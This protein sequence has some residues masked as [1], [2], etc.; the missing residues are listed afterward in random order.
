MRGVARVLSAMPDLL[1]AYNPRNCHNVTERGEIV[2]AH[3]HVL[4]PDRRTLCLAAGVCD[5]AIGRFPGPHPIFSVTP[6][7]VLIKAFSAF[8]DQPSQERAA[9]P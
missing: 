5:A 3:H 7:S 2:A 1:S 4:L 6:V 8:L 9:D